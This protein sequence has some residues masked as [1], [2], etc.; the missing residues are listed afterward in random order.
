MYVSD[1][2]VF[3]LGHKGTV[4]R[5]LMTDYLRT[6]YYCPMDDT[7]IDTDADPY[8]QVNSELG[9]PSARFLALPLFNL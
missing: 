6:T 4:T 1:S 2:L 8:G 7:A 5:K 3:C 9:K